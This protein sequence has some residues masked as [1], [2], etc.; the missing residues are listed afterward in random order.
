M[1]SLL[2]S[3]CSGFSVPFGGDGVL[4]SPLY[5]VGIADVEEEDTEDDNNETQTAEVRVDT[6]NG[7]YT[8]RGKLISQHEN[9]SSIASLVYKLHY[10]MHTDSAG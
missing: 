6:P 8:S 1:A 10:I 2:G 9:H 5:A 7:P 4:E 3:T